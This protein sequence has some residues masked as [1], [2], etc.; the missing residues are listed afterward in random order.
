MD[1]NYITLTVKMEVTDISLDIIK[2]KPFLNVNIKYD[3]DIVQDDN[4]IS[5]PVVY[6]IDD[7]G[8][9]H[10]ELYKYINNINKLVS[11]S[12]D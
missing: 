5:I 3:G 12:N 7:N 10:I 9:M 2:D 4:K 1:I 6:D 11:N 8:N